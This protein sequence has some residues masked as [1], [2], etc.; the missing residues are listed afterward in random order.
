MW[1]GLCSLLLL[2]LSTQLFAQLDPNEQLFWCAFGRST[3]VGSFYPFWTC[4]NAA[5]ACS[6]GRQLIKCD[7]QNQHI[8][9]LRIS[10]RVGGTI[11]SQIGYLKDL[12][13]MELSDCPLT[14]SIPEEIGNLNNLYILDLTNTNI[15]GTLPQTITKLNK[16]ETIL[17]PQGL[18]TTIPENIGDL[19]ALTTLILG[20]NFYGTL[21]ESF[22]K[23]VNLRLLYIVDSDLT[24]T[25]PPSIGDFSLLQFLTI[26]DNGF[27]G[28][29]PDI[30]TLTSLSGLVISEKEVSGNIHVSSLTNLMDITLS[31]NSPIGICDCFHQSEL[32]YCQLTNVIYPCNCTLP[33]RCASIPCHSNVCS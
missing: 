20:S 24:G 1:V 12:T 15:T 11:P 5:R 23:L 19:N 27:I 28:T 17:F 25:I 13:Y 30:S 14:G 6:A 22:G 33:S 7:A 4:D 32:R 2:C 9:F 8:T 29:I 26:A 3:N 31:S 10:E 21:P 18:R 16:M